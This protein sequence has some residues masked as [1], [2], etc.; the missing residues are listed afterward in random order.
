MTWWEE[1]GIYRCKCVECGFYF[2]SMALQ[3]LELPEIQ[4]PKCGT[5]DFHFLRLKFSRS[6][7]GDTKS[8]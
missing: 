3:G 5:K 6:N 7:N 4:C 1:P 2:E 8:I